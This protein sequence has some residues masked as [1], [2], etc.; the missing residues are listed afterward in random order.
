[1]PL[2]KIDYSK[3]I[4][5]TH[6]DELIKGLLNESMRIYNYGEDKISIFTN[7]FGKHHFSTAAAEIEIRAKLAEY[8]TEGTSPN[9]LRQAHILD[10]SKYI[11]GFIHKYN[12]PKGIIFTITFEDWDVRWLSGDEE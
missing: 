9:N 3:E 11:E 2:I 6:I 5:E 12:I 10:F 4:L 7:S 1:M 8:Q